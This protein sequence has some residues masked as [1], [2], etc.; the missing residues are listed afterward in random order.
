[1]TSE[2]LAQIRARQFI[3]PAWLVG[4]NDD[5][6][7][8]CVFK[9]RN[10]VGNGACSRAATIPACHDAVEFHSTLLDEGYKHDGAPRLKQHA[11]VDDV[12]GQR[13]TSLRLADDYKIKAASDSSDL[14]GS[15]GNARADCAGLK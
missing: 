3:I 11:L 2:M 15:A 8:L 6:N 12:V 5:F 14:I 4:N 10:C 1:M 7:L 9:K 13:V